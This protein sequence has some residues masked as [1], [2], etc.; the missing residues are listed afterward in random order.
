LRALGAQSAQLRAALLAEFAA[1][2][3]VA[4]LLAGIAATAMA[5]GL[6]RWVFQL[7]YLPSPGIL[8]A[9]VVVGS[10]GVMGAGLV[11]T[12]RARAVVVTAGLREAG[13]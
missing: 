10:L 2:G 13:A 5:T 3:G 4:G 8:L 1:L 7:D 11:A 6:A 9:G 12:R